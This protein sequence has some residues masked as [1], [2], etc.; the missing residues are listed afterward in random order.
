MSDIRV[1]FAPSPTGYLHIGGVRTALFNWLF[2]RHNKGTYLLRIEDTD[3]ERSTEESVQVIIEGLK[4]LGLDPDEPPI[5]QS[6]RLEIYRKK[7]EE[8]VEQGKAYRCYCTPEELQQVR[9]EQKKRKENP[10][11]NKKCR[12]LKD[13]DPSKP[14]V[15]RLAVPSE[16]TTVFEDLV[17]G[18][19]EIKNTELDDLVILKADG[20]PTYHFAVVIDDYDMNISHV[21]RGDDHLINTPKHVRIAEALGVPTPKYAHLPMILGQDK[22]RLSKRHGAV[23]VLEYREQGFLPDGLLNYLVKLGWGFGDEEF[24]TRE[25]MIEKFSFEGVN[26]SPAAWDNDKLLWLSGEHMRAKPVSEITQA[27]LPILIEQNLITEDQVKSEEELK[28]LEGVISTL[29]GRSKVL[30]DIPKVGKYYFLE[31]VE[32]DPKAK[33]KFLKSEIKEVLQEIRDGLSEL[34]DPLPHDKMEDLFKSVMEKHELKMGK[35]AQ[36]VRVA[37]TGGTASPGIFDVIDQIG[38]TK[39]LERL[40]KSI[41]SI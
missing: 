36:P 21:I 9:E 28:K 37:L 4:W 18:R 40:D 3:R 31:D 19:N 6:T 15:I 14:H 24:F 26:K 41:K 20:Y 12:D 39:A 29:Q 27:V 22:T 11:Y 25:D 35:V 32:Y 17:F 33:E 1:R 5:R 34:D 13:G 16:G 7:A 2:A 8:L 30:L 23:S 10:R 38:K